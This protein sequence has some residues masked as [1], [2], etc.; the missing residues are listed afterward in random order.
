MHRT[1]TKTARGTLSKPLASSQHNL[2]YVFNKRLGKQHGQMLPYYLDLTKHKN[3]DM[4]TTVLYLENLHP[5]SIENHLGTKGQLPVHIPLVNK[6]GPS[7]SLNSRAVNKLQ[8]QAC[9]RGTQLW[10]KR[11]G[12]TSGCNTRHFLN[13]Q[14]KGHGEQIQND[15]LSSDDFLSVL[16]K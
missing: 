15:K 2:R 7:L 8:G 10:W 9:G 5:N 3:K 14:S 12:S 11:T 6:V 13:T 1:A 4:Y 16:T